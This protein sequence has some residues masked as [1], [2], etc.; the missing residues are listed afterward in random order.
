MSLE[1]NVLATAGSL[2]GGHVVV[3]FLYKDKN[4]HNRLLRLRTRVKQKAGACS[5]W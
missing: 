2:R 5:N 1:R 3:L 4:G